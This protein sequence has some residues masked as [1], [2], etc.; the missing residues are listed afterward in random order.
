MRPMI[1]VQPT[2]ELRRPFAVWATEQ[3]P[4]VRTVSTTAFAV[5]V[6]LFVSAPEEIL[7]GALI[8]GHR[9]VSPVEDAAL[10]RPGPGAPAPAPPGQEP[11]PAAS[12]DTAAADAASLIAATPP[13]LVDAAMPPATVAAEPGDEGAAPATSEGVFPCPHCD[14]QLTTARGRDMHARK[15]HGVGV[16]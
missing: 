5:P 14:R 7:I 16:E 12:V 11:A 1:Q 15:V 13:A 8:D 3:R 10:G 2:P 4:K 9:Y 6:E